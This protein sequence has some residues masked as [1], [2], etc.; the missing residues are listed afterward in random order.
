MGRSAKF[1]KRQQTKKT[2]SGGPSASTTP[3]PS[4]AAA[5]APTPAEQK[6]RAGL[7]EKAKAS[8]HRRSGDAGPVLGGADYVALMLGGRRRARAEAAKL[9]VDESADA[10]A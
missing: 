3:A 1:H 6:K 8:T 2:T 10:D 5:S 4:K 9:P 7:K